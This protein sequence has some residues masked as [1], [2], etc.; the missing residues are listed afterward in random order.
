MTRTINGQAVADANFS[1]WQSGLAKTAVG[2]GLDTG[3]RMFDVVRAMV[4]LIAGENSL[5]IV[6]SEQAFHR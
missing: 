1:V 2:N 5:I 6:H 4:S 3:N